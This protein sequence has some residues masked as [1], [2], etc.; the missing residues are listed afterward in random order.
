MLHKPQEGSSFV[1]APLSLQRNGLG[2][3]FNSENHE[4]LGVG[5]S[6]CQDRDASGEYY[7]VSIRQGPFM[8]KQEDRV[9]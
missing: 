5:T 7:G 8:T 1:P 2:S 3:Q 9:S 4:I 6:V